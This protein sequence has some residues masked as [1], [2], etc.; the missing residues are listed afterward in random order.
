[1]NITHNT[2]ELVMA[3]INLSTEQYECFQEMMAY[4]QD[5]SDEIIRKMKTDGYLTDDS[6]TD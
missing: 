6:S 5:C 2:L 1:M 3:V 4:A